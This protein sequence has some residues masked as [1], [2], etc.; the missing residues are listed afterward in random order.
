M[1]TSIALLLSAIVLALP[2]AAAD[3]TMAFGE[4]IP[5]FCFPQTNSGIELEVIGEALK[6]RGHVLKPQYF[7]LARVPVAFKAGQ[8]DAAMTSLG[9]DATAM[10]GHFGN[11]AVLYDNVL[12]TLASR[13][14]VIN[15][16]ADLKG[17]TVISFQGAVNRYPEWLGALKELGNYTEQ[18]DQAL[19]VKTLM[20]GR[21]DVV[22]SDRNIFHYF[23]RQ[24]QNE[25]FA[26]LPVEEHSFTVLNPQDYRPVFRSKQIRN[27]FNAGLQQLKAT[28]RYRAIYEKYLG[29]DG[30]VPQ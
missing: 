28:G 8:V 15:K 2:A 6:Y 7:P 25:G 17:L 13:H 9:E 14:L 1:P 18:N 21:F 11:P 29:K 20:M 4:K 16:P 3:V 5:P 27:D 30:F 12:I 19:Q 10:G 24:L 22:L 26:I 23:T